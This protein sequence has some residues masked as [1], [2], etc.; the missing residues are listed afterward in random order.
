MKNLDLKLMGVQEMNTLEMKE[1]DGGIIWFLVA[2]AV[3]LCTGCIQNNSFNFQYGTN[4][5]N[6]QTNTS[7][8]DTS[9]N[10]NTLEIPID[11]PIG[12]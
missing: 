3:V 2:A 1:T 6:T 8:N 11:V 5:S 12:Y 10:G 7:V 9:L 4:N